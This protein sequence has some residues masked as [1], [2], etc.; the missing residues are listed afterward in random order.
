MSKF[1]TICVYCGSRTGKNPEFARSAPQYSENFW[2]KIIFG[3]IYGGGNIGLMNEVSKATLAHSGNVTGIIPRHL[4]D[5]EIK[6]NKNPHIKSPLDRHMGLTKLIITET[7]HERKQIMFEEF[8]RFHY[9]S[10]I[11]WN[12]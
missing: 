6:N 9:S 5:L 12:S 1:K 10:W 4:Y 11:S 7:M 2:L 3:L 8:L